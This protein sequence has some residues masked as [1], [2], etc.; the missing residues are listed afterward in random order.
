MIIESTKKEVI[1]KL[2]NNTNID[3]LQD[4]MDWIEFKEL[5]RKAKATQKQVD[6]LVKEIKKDRWSKTKA[7]LSK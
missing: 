1:I 5:S 7:L 3:T 2:P 6:S 4:V